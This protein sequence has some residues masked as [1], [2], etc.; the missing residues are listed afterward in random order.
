MFR[1]K[2]VKFRCS[3]CLIVWRR[4]IPFGVCLTRTSRRGHTGG[5]YHTGG[6]ASVLP[7]FPLRCLP[8]ALNARRGHLSV[9]PLNRGYARTL[10]AS[11]CR[12]ANNSLPSRIRTHN[13][14]HWV[15]EATQD[16]P[17]PSSLKYQQRDGE[18]EKERPLL[19]EKCAC[20][21]HGMGLT[22]QGERCPPTIFSILGRV[23]NRPNQTYTRS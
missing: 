18:T 21:T 2:P 8:S 12:T 16:R 20:M 17:A 10:A 4:S 19:T 13:L 11:H 5:R 23:R 22:R 14:P 15:K 3:L 7:S 1:S 9:F 6:R